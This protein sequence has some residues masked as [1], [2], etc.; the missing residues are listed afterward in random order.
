[1][2]ARVVGIEIIV[3]VRQ[4]RKIFRAR[5]HVKIHQ[6]GGLPVFRLP[7]VIHLHPANFGRMTVGLQMVVVL[8]VSLD[9]HTARV[10]IALFGNALRTPVVPYS[11]LSV[12][13][14][15]RCSAA[16]ERLPCWFEWT[17]SDPNVA[18]FLSERPRRH[19]RCE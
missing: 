15:V 7:Q 9:V 1:M 12:P 5:G 17:G 6:L 4:R 2:E 14:P 19:S 10:P 16:G 8:F 11:K 18:G 13:K 3:M